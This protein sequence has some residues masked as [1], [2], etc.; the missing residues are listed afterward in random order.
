MHSSVHNNGGW[1][2]NACCM[3]RIYMKYF[4]IKSHPPWWRRHTRKCIQCFSASFR[5]CWRLLLRSCGRWN[6]RY[7]CCRVWMCAADRF[8]CVQKSV[9]NYRWDCR[10]V[11]SFLCILL[12]TVMQFHDTH[13]KRRT[14]R[15]LRITTAFAMECWCHGWWCIGVTPYLHNA[16][17]DRHS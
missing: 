15:I 2:V 12:C 6:S 10:P 9:F 14:D 8:F 4:P 7:S 16:R 11:L 13:S 3:Q 5:C 17:N 1:I